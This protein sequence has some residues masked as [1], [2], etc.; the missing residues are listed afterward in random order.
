VA[1][2]DNDGFQDL[3]L[4]YPLKDPDHRAA[5]YRNIGGLRFERVPFPAIEDWV[6]HPESQGLPSGALWFDYDNDGDQDLLILGGYGQTRLLQNRLIEH[7]QVSFVDVS[8]EAGL[9]D[10]TIALAANAFDFDRDGRLDLVICSAFNPLLPGYA[11]P[12]R[13]NL[14]KLPGPEYPGDRRMFDIMH[15]TW[16]DANN[17]GGC[18]FYHNEGGR[19]EKRDIGLRDHR[20]SLAVGTGDL[21]NDGYTDLYIAN[22]FGPDQLYL[23]E[24]GLRL[25]MITGRL[26][27]SVGRDTYKG[28]NASIGDLD[29]N[30]FP[31]IYVSN[32]HEK[33]QAE[34]SLLWMNNGKLDAVG[35]GALTDEAMSRNAL[36]ER[37]FG[38][39]AAMGDLDRDGRLDI[40]QANGMV[41][42]SYDPLYPGCPDYWYWND[43]IALTNPDNHGHADRWADLRG[44]CIFAGEKDRVYLNLGRYF[45]DVADKVGI[46]QPGVSRAVALADFEN[47][48]KLDVVITH[49]FAEASLYRNEPNQNGWIG[50]SLRGDGRK[51][52]VDALGS[53]VIIETPAGRQMREV[54]ASNGFSA[55][56]DRRLLF[57]LGS[58]HGPVKARIEWCG[59]SV[60]EKTLD[61]GRYHLLNQR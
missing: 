58:Y 10:Y 46:T 2:F 9:D 50:L 7:G 5:L 39:G 40:V 13:F 61:P 11:T 47:Q 42:N 12:T 16:H 19:F 43:K 38:W 41:D 15:R 14:F 52:N 32:V 31:D 6:R 49:Q 44:R 23:N 22:D 28:M 53:K 33:L 54:Q 37:R 29:N 30:G 34:G 3:F 8:R 48:G 51:C 60:E 27:G 35:S 26:V 55:Q 18:T 24:G 25:R 36:N 1:D 59:V 57:G 45:V 21:N 20:W 56:G 17:G 4:T